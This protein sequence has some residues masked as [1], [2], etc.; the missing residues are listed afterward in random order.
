[1]VRLLAGPMGT[2]VAGF[3]DGHVGI[4][5]LEDGDLLDQTRLHGAAVHLLLDGTRLIMASEL[6]DHRVMDLEAFHASH[7]A[8][9]R[10]IWKAVPV[11]WERGRSRLREPP[12]HHRCA[13]R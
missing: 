9:L 8:L 7:C 12:A 2:V 10:R 1:V 6:G 4:W 3:A 11:V 13:A 5:N